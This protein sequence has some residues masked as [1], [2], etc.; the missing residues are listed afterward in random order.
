MSLVMGQDGKRLICYLEVGEMSERDRK[1]LIQE[2]KT[3]IHKARL[4]PEIILPVKEKRTWLQSIS[5]LIRRWL[6]W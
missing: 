3:A 6:P 1:E 5:R 4:N 2:W